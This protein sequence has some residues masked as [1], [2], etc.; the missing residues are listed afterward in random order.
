MSK[1]LVAIH[2]ITRKPKTKVETV[3]PGARF[4][5]ADD[6]ERDFLLR[7]KAARELT[8]DESG[9]AKPAAK[10]ASKPAE[11]KAEAPATEPEKAVT[12]DPEPGVGNADDTD[13]MLS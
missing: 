12:L 13:G 4:T 10:K 7:S 9:A 1:E 8:A 6:A 5:P 11:K 3:A 2:A